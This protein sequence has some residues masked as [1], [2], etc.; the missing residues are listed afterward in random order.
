MVAIYGGPFDETASVWLGADLAAV[1]T[2]SATTF[3][4]STSTPA[5]PQEESVDVAVE[6]TSERGE[7]QAA[8]TYSEPCNGI[9]ATPSSVSFSPAGTSAEVRITLDGCATGV[10]R[11]DDTYVDSSGVTYGMTWSSVPS[12]VDGSTAVTLGY[13]ASARTVTAY[14][15]PRISTDQGPVSVSVNAGP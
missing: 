14:F 7:A 10:V 3:A 13:A 2:W 11:V 8:F 15:T 6:T 5:H 9:A 1:T 12:A 4:I